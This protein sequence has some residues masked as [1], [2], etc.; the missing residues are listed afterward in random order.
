MK[1]YWLI[2]KLTLME[3]FVYRLNFLLWQFRNVVSFLALFFF[4]QAVYSGRQEI[5]GYQREQMLSY[6]V[7][8]SVLRG[9]VFGSRTADLAGM[10][11]SG[12]LV[13][14]FLLRPWSI[15][16]AFFC[17]DLAAKFLDIIFITLEIYLISRLMRVELF[18]PKSW[19]M[20]ILFVIACLLS[21]LLYFFIS[22]LLSTIAFWVDNVWAPRWLFGIIFLEFMSGA[23]FPL[24]VLPSFVLKI[25]NLTPFPYLIYF[26]LKIGLG[27]LAFGKI[28]SVLMIMVFWLILAV[29]LTGSVWRKGLKSYSAYGG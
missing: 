7:G 8:V 5:F 13:N 21:T 12:D 2:F 25:I 19:G 26:P 16:K 23:F 18:L 22:F 15:V 29:L 3:Y 24:D 1:K 27:Q 20:I 17:R 9:I 4:W 6:I 14:R 11:R 28:A 10:I